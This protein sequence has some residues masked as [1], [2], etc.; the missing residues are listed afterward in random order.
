MNC[1]YLLFL[2]GAVATGRCFVCKEKKIFFFHSLFLFLFW[3]VTL[4]NKINNNNQETSKATPKPLNVVYLRRGLFLFRNGV[5]HTV[6][7]TFFGS[8]CILWIDDLQ[9][10]RFYEN[11]TS[12]VQGRSKISLYATQI[13]QVPGS[14]GA[15]GHTPKFSSFFENVQHF[16]CFL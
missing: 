15:R 1:G 8:L 13:F 10:V 5:S 2:V 14:L 12:N 3:I 11:I 6:A 7:C 9:V 4:S 16:A